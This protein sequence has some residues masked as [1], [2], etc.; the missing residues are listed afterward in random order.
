MKLI[1]GLAAVL[2]GIWQVY[3]SKKYFDNLKEQSSPIIFAL[4][5]LV[6]SLVFAAFLLV[7]GAMTLRSL[8]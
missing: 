4:I 3:V 2:I 1:I 7:Y 5:A 8:Y 6:A